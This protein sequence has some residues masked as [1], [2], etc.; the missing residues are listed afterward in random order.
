MAQLE[1]LQGEQQLTLG[2]GIW[3]GTLI[4]EPNSQPNTQETGIYQQGRPQWGK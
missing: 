4:F 1:H 2:W 3:E